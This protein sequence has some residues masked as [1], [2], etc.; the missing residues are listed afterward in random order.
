[1]YNLFKLF[2][3][4][5]KEKKITYSYGGIDNL[6]IHI[7][8]KKENGFYIDVGCGHPIK[9]NNTYQLHK[10]GWHGINVDLSK[11]CIE[12]FNYTRKSDHNVNIAISDKKGHA[13]L[14]FYH[15]KS[16][17]N[18]IDEKTYI[19]QKAKITKK[20]KVSTDTL[21]SVIEKSPFKNS[22]IDFISID[23]EGSELNVLKNFN[24]LKYSPKILVVEYLDL[25]L[26]H[27]EIKNLDIENVLKS[28][29]YKF[30]ISKNYTLI[31]WL[32]SDLVFAHKSFKD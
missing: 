7:F 2:Y 17:I 27:L 28:E 10:K 20:I 9:N 16:P 4:S 18:T 31:N 13:E 1:M 5:L 21:D 29:V 14:F 23:V 25:K 19:Y 8:K 15:D 3:K 12:L 11:S 22:Q 26:P 24:F 30:I 32:H 6:L